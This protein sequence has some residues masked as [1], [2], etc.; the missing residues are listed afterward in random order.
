MKQDHESL[1]AEPNQKVAVM[2]DLDEVNGRVGLSKLIPGQIQVSPS[3]LGTN[4]LI[5]LLLVVK[6]MLQA[7]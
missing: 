6:G 2:V 5:L 3:T 4:H 7:D 1:H